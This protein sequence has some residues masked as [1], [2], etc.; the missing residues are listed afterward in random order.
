[1]KYFPFNLK[2][3]VKPITHNFTEKDEFLQ[4]KPGLNRAQETKLLTG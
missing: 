2:S 4:R 3:H 1:M